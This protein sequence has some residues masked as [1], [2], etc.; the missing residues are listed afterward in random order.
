[1]INLVGGILLLTFTCLTGLVAFAKY[2]SCDLLSSKKISRGE[3]VIIFLIEIINFL[4][5]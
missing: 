2:H 1:M 4:F 3:Q 5:F